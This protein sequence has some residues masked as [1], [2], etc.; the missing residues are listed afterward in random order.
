MTAVRALARL[1]DPALRL[2]HVG[3]TSEARCGE[4]FAR[5]AAADPRIERRGS[6]PHAAT[7]R[8]IARGRVLLLP[9]VMLRQGEPVFLDD[10]TLADLQR[11]LPVPIRL[12]TGADDLVAVCSGKLGQGA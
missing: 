2:V 10:T 8:L 1:P 6:L 3:G 12:I 11:Q 9:S 7:R 4:A 5:A